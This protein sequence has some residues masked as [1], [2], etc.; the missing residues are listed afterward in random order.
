MIGMAAVLL[1]WITS[2]INESYKDNFVVNN[3]SF[4]TTVFGLM[5][6]YSIFIN[7]GDLSVVLLVGSIISL[8]VLLVGVFLKNNEIVICDRFI[9]STTAYQGYAGNIDLNLIHSIN[10]FTTIINIQ[11]VTNE[12]ISNLEC[13]KNQLFIPL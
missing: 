11:M 5:M 3:S 2:E 6:L 10:N 13:P 1:S 8:V 12:L 7:A 4:L 9:D